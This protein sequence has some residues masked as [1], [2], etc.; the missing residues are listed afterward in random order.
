LHE[1]IGELP[2]IFN[3]P[4]FLQEYRERVCSAINS[5]HGT[6]SGSKVPRK[7]RTPRDPGAKSEAVK[8]KPLKNR[9]VSLEDVH[10]KTATVKRKKS[11][12]PYKDP[13]AGEKLEMLTKIRAQR[14]SL[15]IEK[16]EAIK[17][18]RYVYLLIK[19]G[20]IVKI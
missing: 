3:C 18:A 2:N 8:R 5:Y 20:Q 4:L 16:K 14:T 11:T 10:I 19:R 12:A 13:M 7:P 1:L 9:P 15:E 17:R 6:S